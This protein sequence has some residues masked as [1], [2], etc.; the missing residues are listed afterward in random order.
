[1]KWHEE[2]LGKPWQANPN[3]PESFNCGELLR[4]VYKKHFDYDAPIL[5]ADALDLRSCVRDVQNIQR[6]YSNMKKVTRAQDF[7]LAVLWR[8]IIP[9]HVGLYAAG[10]ILHCRPNVGV[11]L[12]DAFTIESFGWRKIEYY[13]PEGLTPCLP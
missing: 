8:G 4:Y 13:R 9:D 12:D 3:P 7:D 10:S 2:Y 5:L 1:M 6:Y 11:F